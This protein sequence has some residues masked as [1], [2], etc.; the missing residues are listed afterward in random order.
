[1]AGNE[2]P[3]FWNDLKAMQ[4][5]LL[6]GFACLFVGFLIG[7]FWSG[8]ENRESLLA[9]AVLGTAG[10]ALYQ[11]SIARKRHEEQTKA[12]QDRRITDNFTK[13]IELLGKPELE[14]Q[15]RVGAIYAL[16]RIAHESKR[17][18]WPIMET[19]TAY[20]RTKA[21]AKKTSRS[22][23]GLS[24]DRA[25]SAYTAAATE[26]TTEAEQGRDQDPDPKLAAD[27]QA[28]LTILRERKLEHEEKNH[29][30]DLTG[31]D[32][33][34]GDLSKVSMRGASLRGTD[35]RGA[36]LTEAI[37][38]EA[39]LPGDKE[40]GPT[41]TKED[42]W[43]GKDD[44]FLDISEVMNAFRRD[45]YHLVKGNVIGTDLRNA[46]L[47]EA[48]LIRTKLNGAN[49]INADLTGAILIRAD[50]SDAYLQNANLCGANLRGAIL[51]GANLTNADLRGA[52]LARA[53]LTKAN[54]T[55]AN[56]EGADLDSAD[57]CKTAM[58]DGTLNNRNCPP[59]P[60]PPEDPDES[61]NWL[62]N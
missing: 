19:L 59:E 4:P 22:D 61:S 50:L 51:S 26:G 46:D 31:A 17:D 28:V 34:G 23:Q 1:M 39:D 10:T 5:R 24:P 57:F 44:P 62:W 15:V 60:T 38:I 11:A 48:Y 30:I 33:H 14:L 42:L 35:F 20:V 13:A 27:I 54:L 2:K 18:H 16:A 21:P 55:K 32:L 40:S 36:N 43:E 37:L 25:A 49:L 45:D 47:R 8:K 12:D 52:N 58:P 29:R 41:W 3:G 6:A 9:L 53:N 7:L 56:L